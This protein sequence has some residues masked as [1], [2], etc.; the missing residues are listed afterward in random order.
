M[1]FRKVI[2][3]FLVAATTLTALAG[4][5]QQQDDGKVH[6][7]IG[8]WPSEENQVLY[9]RYSN[10]LA[11][12]SEENPDVVLTPDTY[13]FNTK[14][15][16]AKAVANQLPTVFEAPFTEAKNIP[17]AGYCQDVSTYLE[18]YGM[19]DNLNP[20]LVDLVRGEN[21]EIWGVPYSV[22]AQ[23]LY[24]NKATFKEAGLVN[25][26]GSVKVPNTYEEVAEYSKII[27]EKTGKA[28]FVLPTIDNCGGW[29]FINVA[30]SYGT[31]F[32]KQDKDGKWIATFNSPE[33]KSAVQWLYDMKW[34]YN[35]LPEQF[36]VSND[37]RSMMFGT[38][39]AAMMFSTPPA[40]ELSTKFGMNIADIACVRMPEGPDQRAAQL[41]GNILFFAKG[42][43]QEQFNA[44]M[45]WYFYKGSYSLE[46]TDESLA[47]TEASYQDSLKAGYIVIPGSVLPIIVNRDNEDKLQAL[48]EKYTNVDVKDYADYLSFEGVALTPEEPACCQQ[49]YSIMDNIVQKVITDKNVDIDTLINEA[50][51]D[52][53][54][55]HLD[56]M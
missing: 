2:A 54:V 56:N 38:G 14:D 31:E 47:K 53:Q 36:A 33:F 32:M 18:E 5:G 26:D 41:G 42:T 10:N 23:G 40:N 34:E 45:D 49:L 24:I 48:R 55:N 8:N 9:E 22:Y 19:L 7:S 52:F 3:T 4:C 43:T 30:W 35:A 39:Q 20:D 44:C 1:K 29:H 46:I 15:F 13:A 25:E 28:G 11:G 27:R 37:D 21:G 12:F 16:V 17:N 50:V 51:N 6:I